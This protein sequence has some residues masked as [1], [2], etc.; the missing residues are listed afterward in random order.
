[1]IRAWPLKSLCR[2]PWPVSSAVAPLLNRSIPIEE[3][4]TPD[5][6]ADRFYPIKLGQVLNKRYQVAT[7]LG[8]GASSTVWL[9]RD[10]DR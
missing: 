1:M 9:A 6:H 8:H 2:R 4:N 10:L 7:K 3:E 5:Y